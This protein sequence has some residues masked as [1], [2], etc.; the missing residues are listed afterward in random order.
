MNVKGAVEGA[1]GPGASRAPGGVAADERQGPAVD[2]CS[3]RAEREAVARELRG[4]GLY[5]REVAER[6]GVA[7]STADAYLND[8]GGKRLRARKGGYRGKCI[9]CG[10]PTDGS[11]GP[12]L[13]PLRCDACNR[14]LLIEAARAR[15]AAHRA[16]VEALWAAGKTIR[17]I[18]EAF[19]FKY[20]K[21]IVG[22]WRARGYN[23]PHRRSPEQVARLTLSGR[24]NLA[25]ARAKRARKVAA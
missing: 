5:V 6:M 15:A 25:V 3:T 7:V 1:V 19:G 16:E 18:C 14:P 11:N 22:N 21:S 10:A 12:A 13:A 9:D 4:Q 24:R 23:L 8:P 20:N 17:E 2:G